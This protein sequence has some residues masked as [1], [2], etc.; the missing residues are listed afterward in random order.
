MVLAV[1]QGVILGADGATGRTAPVLLSVKVSSIGRF[2][3]CLSGLLTGVS[4]GKG[5]V[6]LETAATLKA[7]HLRGLRRGLQ[8][9]RGG[10]DPGKQ[11]ASHPPA[12][13]YHSLS[14]HRALQA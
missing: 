3:A 13:L 1:S 4:P 2:K 14:W 9:R 12:E 5:D 10:G 11:T 7:I 6:V 8:S